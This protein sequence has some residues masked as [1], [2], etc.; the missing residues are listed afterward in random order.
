M[1]LTRRVRRGLLASIVPLSL[2]VSLVAWGFAS[3][4]GASPD[5]E[6][7]MASIWCGAGIRDGLCE[8]GDSPNERRVPASLVGREQE[9]EIGPMSGRSNVVFWLEK[10]G[11][12]GSDDAVDRV[13]AR[14]KAAASLLTE[15][16]IRAELR[17][18]N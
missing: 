17:V 12:A 7:H 16:E 14:A 9:I 13:F 3:P 10:R 15:E 18:R 2:F 5:D 6:Y 1:K 8:E 11:H 4:V